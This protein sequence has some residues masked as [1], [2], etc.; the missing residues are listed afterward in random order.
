MGK[1]FGWRNKSHP[2]QAESVSGSAP[3]LAKL[4]LDELTQHAEVEIMLAGY[5]LSEW[6]DSRV[7]DPSLIDQAVMHAEWAT[8]ALREIKRRDGPGLAK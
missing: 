4:P 8:D 6:R 3:R 2:P 5:K 7:I 1:V